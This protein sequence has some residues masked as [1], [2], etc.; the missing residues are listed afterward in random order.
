M[1]HSVFSVAG[2]LAMTLG[3]F[4]LFLWIPVRSLPRIEEHPIAA[5]AVT[6]VA[7]VFGLIGCGGLAGFSLRLTPAVLRSLDLNTMRTDVTQ[8]VLSGYYAT[9]AI[10][11]TAWLLGYW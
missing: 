2:T 10:A 9:V 11:A 7:V 5:L 6:S 8:L 1:R 3:L 4:C